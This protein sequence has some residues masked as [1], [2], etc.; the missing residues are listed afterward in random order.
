M[1]PCRNSCRRRSAAQATVFGL[2][3]MA[4]SSS[5]A[6]KWDR[7]KTGRVPA[8]CSESMSEGCSI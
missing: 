2:A 5:P 8:V 7:R 3:S 6:M 4:A 1:E